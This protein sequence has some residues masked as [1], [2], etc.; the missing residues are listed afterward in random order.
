MFYCKSYIE[1]GLSIIM[2]IDLFTSTSHQCGL[3]CNAPFEN[4]PVGI[5]FD[6]ETADVTMEFIEAAP[7]HMNIPV[8]EELVESLL[9]AKIIH[10]GFLI[11]NEIQ[12]TVSVPLFL[13]NDPY[14]GEFSNLNAITKP[15][16]SVLMFEEFMTRCAYAQALHR[17]HLGDEQ[18]SLSILGRNDPKNLQFAASLTRQRQQELQGPT[19]GPQLGPRGAELAQTPL[20]SGLTPMGPGGSRSA[21]SNNRTQPP[22]R[23]RRDTDE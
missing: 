3:I 12:D 11:D 1:Y 4:T 8:Q 10:I 17:D 23:T 19:L 9:A 6:A 21:T 7:F 15:V 22:H 20:M 5:I 13:L 18:D 2:N 16:R 14:G